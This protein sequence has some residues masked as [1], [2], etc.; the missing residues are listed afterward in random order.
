LPRKI[1][2]AF[3]TIT[4]ELYSIVFANNNIVGSGKV[5][6][7]FVRFLVSPSSLRAFATDAVISSFVF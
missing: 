4:R 7:A 5:N 1:V 3:V 2:N 6:H